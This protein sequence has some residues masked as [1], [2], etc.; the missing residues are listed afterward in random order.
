[1]K[2]GEAAFP[3]PMQPGRSVLVVSVQKQGTYSKQSLEADTSSGYSQ[4]EAGS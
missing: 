4:Q 3:V 2:V 1:M